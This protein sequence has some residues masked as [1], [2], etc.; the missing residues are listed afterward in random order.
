MRR[1]QHMHLYTIFRM[2]CIACEFNALCVQLC[3]KPTVMQIVDQNMLCPHILT[4]YGSSQKRASRV[5]SA[6]IAICISRRS[7][8][9]DDERCKCMVQ[10]STLVHYDKY[11][12]YTMLY[13]IRNVNHVVAM[14]WEKRSSTVRASA[15]HTPHTHKKP[16]VSLQCCCRFR[17]C[18]FL[19][20]RR[21]SACICIGVLHISSKIQW[22]II[23]IEKLW[24]Y[25]FNLSLLGK[26]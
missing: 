7:Q 13:H 22:L 15:P 21:A 11:M 19:S 18:V 26:N 1:N 20:A 16:R 6:R 9:V 23:L 12:A 4:H 25:I 8:T 14:A 24:K 2:T 5:R 10:C 3:A 17:H